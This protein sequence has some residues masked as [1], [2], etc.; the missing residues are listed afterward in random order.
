MKIN[1]LIPFAFVALFF[2]T[3]CSDSESNPTPVVEEKP[4]EASAKVIETFHKSDAYYQL[5]VYRYDSTASK[6]TAKIGSH[7]STIPQNEPSYLGFTN[8]YVKESGVNLFGMTTIYA[9]T[10]GTSNIK[11]ARINA[12]K[13]LQFFPDATAAKK[14]TVK[15]VGQNIVMTKKS[16]NPATISIGISGQGTYDEE[17]KVIDLTV[18][19]N[20][21]SIGGKSSV[22]R[23]YKLSVDALTLN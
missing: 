17:T 23:K 18:Y 6:W 12:E 2:A 8:P 1:K 13:V 19:F 22:A 11:E 15:V 5:N 16:G 14:G 21:T 10:L 3:A 7:F 20:E 9:D 4:A